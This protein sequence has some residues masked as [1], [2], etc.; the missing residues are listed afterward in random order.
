M[1]EGFGYSHRDHNQLEQ[2]IMVNTKR[3]MII[4][5]SVDVGLSF[6]IVLEEGYHNDT[7]LEV[8]IFTN[9]LAA[10]DNFRTGLYD[11]IIT[12]TVMPNIN[13]FEV[14]IKLRELDDKVKVCFWY[15]V[16]YTKKLQK[17]CF[18]N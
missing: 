11:L 18:L 1:L 9:L 13:G 16:R 15:L 4:D 7:K 3:I 5:P 17:K 12:A 2:P 10:L 6:K 8:D 14:Y